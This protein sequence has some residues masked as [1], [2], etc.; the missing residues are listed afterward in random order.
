MKEILN[1]LNELDWENLQMKDLKVIN[2]VKGIL[3][4]IL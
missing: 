1:K 4:E 3:E 2:Q